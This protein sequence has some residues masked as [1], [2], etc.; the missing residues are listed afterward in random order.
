MNYQSPIIPLDYTLKIICRSLSRQVEFMLRMR[1]NESMI[2]P[3]YSA[4]IMPSLFIMALVSSRT[5][6][7]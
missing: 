6:E 5:S 4:V 3:G 1:I 7:L 2:D